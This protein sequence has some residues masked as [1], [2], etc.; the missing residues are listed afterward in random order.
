M[1]SSSSCSKSSVASGSVDRRASRF[2]V[3][4]VPSNEKQSSKLEPA[5]QTQPRGKQKKSVDH[6]HW[7]LDSVSYMG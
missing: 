1:M 7:Q 2:A 3:P 4:Y 5:V 6:Y